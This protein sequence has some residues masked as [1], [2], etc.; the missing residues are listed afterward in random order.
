MDSMDPATPYTD[1]E[2]E[3]LREIYQE[4][5]Q[6]ED[7]TITHSTRRKRSPSPETDRPRRNLRP[8]LTRPSYVAPD[9]EEDDPDSD[10]SEDAPPT[11]IQPNG[12]TTNRPSIPSDTDSPNTGPSPTSQTSGNTTTEPLTPSNTVP[13]SDASPMAPK[14]MTAT[15]EPGNNSTAEYDRELLSI[16]AEIAS[17]ETRKANIKAQRMDAL[18]LASM[19]DTK[20]SEDTLMAA[21]VDANKMVD[22]DLHGVLKR[23]DDQDAELA[24]MTREL[25]GRLMKRRIEVQ[26]LIDRNENGGF[27]MPDTKNRED[28]LTAALVDETKM[29][30]EDLYGTLERLDNYIIKLT[31][32][33][34]AL[35]EGLRRRK[36]EIKGLIDANLQIPTKVPDGEGEAKLEDE[37]DGDDGVIDKTP[38]VEDDKEDGKVDKTSVAENGDKIEEMSTTNDEEDDEDNDGDNDEEY[39]SEYDMDEDF[40]EDDSSVYDDSD[41]DYG[42]G[43]P[44][45]TEHI[46]AEDIGGAINEFRGFDVDMDIDEEYQEY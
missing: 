21:L 7:V 14:I 23:L 1:A 42:D 18:F 9:P 34:E 3:I 40:I 43:R 20:E 13:T 29:S 26:E 44:D 22:E 46:V 36:R 45:E 24:K 17:L 38:V 16:E 6:E 15:G 39:E 27:C 37:N 33:T 41:D 4:N 5:I 10:S 2:C 25:F 28:T 11:A 8:R 30:D 32:R 19:S 12:N 31:K 35:F